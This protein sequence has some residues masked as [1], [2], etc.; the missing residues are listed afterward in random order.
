VQPFLDEI[1]HQD[2]WRD[3]VAVL[4]RILD[5]ERDPNALLAGLDDADT[6]IAGDVLQALGVEVSAPPP[7]EEAQGMTLD[8]LLDLVAQ[9]CRPDA[10]AGLAEQLH[11]LTRGISTDASMPDDI[12]ALGRVLNAILSGE[13]APDLSALPPA[14]AEAV[15]GMLAALQ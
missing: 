5:G 11:A 15:R 14:L 3:L 13:R 4:R 6:I 10:P 2:D 1:A 12:R 7:A 8:A 9:A